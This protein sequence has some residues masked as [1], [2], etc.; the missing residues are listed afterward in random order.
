MAINT[1]ETDLVVL[2]DIA[3][4]SGQA[5]ALS[6]ASANIIRAFRVE[7]RGKARAVGQDLTIIANQ[8]VFFAPQALIDTTGADAPALFAPGNS[9]RTPD[10]PAQGP[11]HSGT[12]GNAGA[13]GGRAGNVAIFAVS[14]TGPV[15]V[16]AVGGAGSRGQDG[17]DGGT[18]GKG[19]DARDAHEPLGDC[20]PPSGGTGQQGGQGGTAGAPG[21]SGAGG[22]LDIWLPAGSSAPAIAATLTGG[23]APP[24][25]AAG[26]RGN[27]GLGGNGAFCISPGLPGL[28]G[29]LPALNLQ[30]VRVG[31]GHRGGQGLS[32]P[33]AEAQMK[34]PLPGTN[35]LLNGKEADLSPPPTPFHVLAGDVLAAN[36]SPQ[37]LWTVLLKAEQ[38]Y[39]NDR[40]EEAT[41]RLLWIS[42][43]A[44]L[45][46]ATAGAPSHA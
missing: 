17:G 28:Q 13:D 36:C 25:A 12:P 45:L 42:A 10:T 5:F 21:S 40:F 41:P 33:A 24:P 15:N 7:I 27:G 6:S 3:A 1:I 20:P 2:D 39:L 38:H 4:A 9:P 35:G 31:P 26:A 44:Q 46:S 22:N 11:G 16:R 29:V 14:I 8:V 30:V 37:Q 43:M 18:G 23:A 32:G 34:Q 19:A